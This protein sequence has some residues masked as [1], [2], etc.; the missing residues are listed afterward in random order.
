[1]V[2]SSGN[3]ESC[4][5]KA[6]PMDLRTGQASQAEV[7]AYQAELLNYDYASDCVRSCNDN[8]DGALVECLGS[9]EAQCRVAGSE[10]A[11]AE[12]VNSC[13]MASNVAQ[14]CVE[15]C[16]TTAASCEAKC[17][18]RVDGGNGTFAS[19]MECSSGCGRARRQCIAECPKS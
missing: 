6:E 9:R 12:V 16:E 13:R 18:A 15:A 19:C 7:V 14:A 2:V 4:R 17:P 3:I 1:M 10:L 11:I 8:D 5:L